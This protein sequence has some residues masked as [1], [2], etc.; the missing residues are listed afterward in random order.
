MFDNM[1]DVSRNLVQC[2]SAF[3]KAFEDY[4]NNEY[5]DAMV[6]AL[7][8]TMNALNALQDFVND[9]PYDEQVFDFVKG[10]KEQVSKER[11]M[12]LTKSAKL[13]K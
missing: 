8:G 5:Y 11:D 3:S 6:K 10:I 13:E 2:V 1:T 7:D 12:Y 9:Y 4:H